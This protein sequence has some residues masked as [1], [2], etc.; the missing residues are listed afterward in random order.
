MCWVHEALDQFW[1]L[2]GTRG[3]LVVVLLVLCGLTVYSHSA[4]NT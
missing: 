4:T 2:I 3:I 1:E